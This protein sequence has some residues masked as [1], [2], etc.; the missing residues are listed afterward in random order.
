[1]VTNLRGGGEGECKVYSK[2][3]HAVAMCLLGGHGA[4]LRQRDT[5]SS[6]EGL[7][8]AGIRLDSKSA[9]GTAQSVFFFLLC[10]RKN[11]HAVLL[12]NSTHHTPLN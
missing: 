4:K 10:L 11:N 9:R 3:Y 6:A 7:H 8:A 12:T 1:M 2:Q 5:D